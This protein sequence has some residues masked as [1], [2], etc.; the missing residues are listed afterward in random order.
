MLNSPVLANEFVLDMESLTIPT[1]YSHL[2]N[3]YFMQGQPII[4]LKNR[5]H[6]HLFITTLNIYMQVSTEHMLNEPGLSHN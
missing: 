6:N 5:H 1:K 4:S 2:S 3:N